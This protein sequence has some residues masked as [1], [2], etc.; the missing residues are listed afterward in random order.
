MVRRAAH[1]YAP[2]D[3]TWNHRIMRRKIRGEDFFAIYEVFYEGKKVDGWTKDEMAPS[4]DT[5]KDLKENYEQMRGAF[6]APVLD[7]KTGKEI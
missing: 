6:K 3:M 1:G 5:L 7:F 2:I 4:G